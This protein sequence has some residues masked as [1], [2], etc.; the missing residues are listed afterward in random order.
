MEHFLNALA[1]SKKCFT[2]FGENLDIY[3][4]KT[5]YVLA[6]IKLI[7]GPKITAEIVDC[8]MDEVQI[9]KAVNVVF[10]KIMEKGKHGVIQYGYKFRLVG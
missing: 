8:E 7:E 4:Q 9:E 1:L 10:R 2:S 6:I 3:F 5:P